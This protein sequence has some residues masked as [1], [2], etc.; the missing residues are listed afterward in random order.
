LIANVTAEIFA[1][2]YKCFDDSCAKVPQKKY[3]QKNKISEF[4]E[5]ERKKNIFVSILAGAIS[6]ERK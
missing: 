6:N 5:I 4:C 3:L 2:K 1:K